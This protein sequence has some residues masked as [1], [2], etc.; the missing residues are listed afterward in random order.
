MRKH[1]KAGR[2]TGK[3][4]PSNKCI[5]VLKNEVKFR[6]LV[7]IMPA[8][9]SRGHSEKFSKVIGVEKLIGKI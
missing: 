9:N 8:I 2:A 6:D 4:H 7:L 3:Q 1:L 5:L